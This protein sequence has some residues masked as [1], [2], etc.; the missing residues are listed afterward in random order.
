[1]ESG[2][3]WNVKN[4]NSEYCV[5]GGTLSTVHASKLKSTFLRIFVTFAYSNINIYGKGRE[6]M[7]F[8]CCK[9]LQHIRDSQ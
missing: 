2:I 8:Q 1:M 5:D 9:I 6:T 7:L 4:N 3:L